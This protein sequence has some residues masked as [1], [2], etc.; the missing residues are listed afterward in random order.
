MGVTMAEAVKSPAKSQGVQAAVELAFQDHL[1]EDCKDARW[2]ISL[3]LIKAL[4]LFA[5]VLLVCAVVV[6]VQAVRLANRPLEGWA[7]TPGGD[8]YQVNIRLMDESEVQTAPNGQLQLRK[9]SP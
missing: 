1:A 2:F 6:L 9:S 4:T 5:A 7:V 8:A 3:W